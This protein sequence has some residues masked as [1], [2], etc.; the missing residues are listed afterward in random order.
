[1]R[2]PRFGSV[3]AA[4]EFGAVGAGHASAQLFGRAH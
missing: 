4:V 1:M 2:P 3:E